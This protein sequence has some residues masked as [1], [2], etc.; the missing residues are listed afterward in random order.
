MLCNPL[1]FYPRFCQSVRRAAAVSGRSESALPRT[2]RPPDKQNTCLAFP[3][4]VA[5]LV[6][7]LIFIL[8]FSQI[9]IFAV[10]RF[11]LVPAHPNQKLSQTVDMPPVFPRSA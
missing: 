10:V 8:V 9:I 5:I 2:A 1:S 7:V 3:I 6:I 11:V 4:F